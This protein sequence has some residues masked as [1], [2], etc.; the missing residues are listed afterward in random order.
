M[1][2]P[3]GRTRKTRTSREASLSTA[4]SSSRPEL[5]EYFY[6]SLETRGTCFKYLLEHSATV[7][8]RKQLFYFSHQNENSLCL[9]HRFVTGPASSGFLRPLF[10]IFE[11]SVKRIYIKF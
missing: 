9:H 3:F 1:G 5:I 7:T 10:G 6:Y 8:K 11:V 2:V 4:F